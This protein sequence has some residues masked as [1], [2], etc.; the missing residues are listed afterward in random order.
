MSQNLKLKTGDQIKMEIGMKIKGHGKEKPKEVLIMFLGMIIFFMVNL[1]VPT[2]LKILRIAG[3]LTSVAVLLT[4][5][6]MMLVKSNR[7][8]SRI[9]NYLL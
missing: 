3:F 1:L 2:Q 7:L 6:I 5:L 9:D 4:S 8:K